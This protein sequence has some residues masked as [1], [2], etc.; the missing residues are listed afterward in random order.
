MKSIIK[1]VNLKTIL[2]LILLA[3]ALFP[4]PLPFAVL[5]ICS[6]QFIQ[7]LLGPPININNISLLVYIISVGSGLAG[8]LFNQ[9]RPKISK[10]LLIFYFVTQLITMTYFYIYSK[11]GGQLIAIFFGYILAPAILYIFVKPPKAMIR[12]FLT[13]VCIIIILNLTYDVISAIGERMKK[14][15]HLPG[16]IVFH[17][18]REERGRLGIYLLEKG[19][20]TRL[21]TGN[22]A[23]FYKDNSYIA[24]QGKADSKSGYVLFN[25]KTNEKQLLP[26]PREYVTWDYNISP[27]GRKIAFTSSK[28]QYSR[29]KV[30][31]TNLFVANIDG[32]EM[33][34]LTDANDTIYHPRWSPDG[35]KI[36]FYTGLDLLETQEKK[37]GGIYVINSDG[38]GLEK[39]TDGDESSWS[40]SGEK[41]VYSHTDKQ[42]VSNIYLLDVKTREIKKITHSN[43][44]N[45]SPV[46]SLDGTK[47][48]FVS[49]RG[50]GGAELYVINIDGT[51]ETQVTPPKKIRAYGRWRYATDSS[52]DWRE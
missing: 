46:F 33:K 42:N 17:S 14:P 21:D 7:S 10:Y 13:L 3:Q 34:Q 8:I 32:S 41:I 35:K 29:W 20:I 47:V 19:R 15:A 40:P 27:D 31:Q 18:E 23:Q 37:A 2:T 51:N 48:L 1:R 16:K 5:L 25:L 52:P 26:F 4:V 38:T 28:A 22:W 24:Y 11:F 50:N 44:W 43:F 45:L 30:P 9:D 36:L 6:K 49:K 12:P 39:L